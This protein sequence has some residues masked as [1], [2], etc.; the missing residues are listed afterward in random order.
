MWASIFI[1]TLDQLDV[2][3]L[4]NSYNVSALRANY[5]IIAPYRVILD[6]SRFPAMP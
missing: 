5:L 1:F 2:I 3:L 6:Y 4:F